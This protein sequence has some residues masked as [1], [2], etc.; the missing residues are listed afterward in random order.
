[1]KRLDASVVQERLPMSVGA[2][3]GSPWY[4]RALGMLTEAEAGAESAEQPAT[5]PAPKAPAPLGALSLDDVSPRAKS[6][7]VALARS[8]G[9]EPDTVLA[10][11]SSGRSIRSLLS[12][13]TASGYGTSVPAPAATGGLAIDEYA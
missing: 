8:L 1:M 6:N 5:E 11:L 2:V 9:V 4:A 13:A 12:G 10:H 3:G 7:L